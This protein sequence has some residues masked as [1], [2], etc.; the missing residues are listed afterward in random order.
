MMVLNIKKD[1]Y[2]DITAV[3]APFAPYRGTR[4]Q[5]ETIPTKELITDINK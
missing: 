1:K 4:Y 3:K 2:A 5:A